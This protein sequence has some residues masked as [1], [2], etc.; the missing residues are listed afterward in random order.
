MIIVFFVLALI[1]ALIQYLFCKCRFTIIK[2]L[3]LGVVL[4]YF[5]VFLIAISQPPV[6]GSPSYALGDML[7]GF[8]FAGALVGIALGWFVHSKMSNREKEDKDKSEE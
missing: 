1:F 5:L 8:L 7:M 2:L 4:A 3:P 6:K